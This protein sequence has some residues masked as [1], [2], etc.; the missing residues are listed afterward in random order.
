MNIS[1]SDLL[2]ALR[3]FAVSG[4]GVIVGAPG[5]GKTFA[6]KHLSAEWMNERSCL[7]L[8]I[9]RLS[10]A[11]EGALRTE[12][13]IQVDFAEYLRTNRDFSQQKGILIIDAFDAARSDFAQ[14]F[15]LGL[16][17]RIMTNL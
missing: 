13:G 4:N 16:A 7:Y 12:L 8:P 5:V 11:N 3:N 1:R 2:S 15:V 14:G 9:D 6:L 10:A 17:R